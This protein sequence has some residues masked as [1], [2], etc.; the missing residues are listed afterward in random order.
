MIHIP[1]VHD[2]ADLGSLNESVRNLTVQKKGLQG[3]RTSRERVDLIW[4]RIED[5]LESLSLPYENVRVFQDGLPVCDFEMNIV[6]ELSDK[7]S[8][9]HQIL[10]RMSERGAEIMGTESPDLLVKEYQ[11]A[12]VALSVKS[13]MRKQK[14]D[15]DRKRRSRF[16]LS[17]RD[18][19][20]ASRI[21]ETLLEGETGI[22][23]LGMLHS[24]FQWLNEDIKV[25]N[26]T[27]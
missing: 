24:I 15:A 4:R 1:I 3:W 20:I 17:K 23:F 9:N 10:Q 19:F 18:Q 7:G 8:R 14:V 27:F 5:F 16:L 13:P 26:H 25:F 21:N 6:K 2:Q 22:L 12:K 11:L